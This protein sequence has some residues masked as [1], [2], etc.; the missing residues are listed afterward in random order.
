ML[1]KTQ[2]VMHQNRKVWISIINRKNKQYKLFMKN[3][4]FFKK[5]KCR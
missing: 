2:Q 4:N 3:M 5:V 1:D